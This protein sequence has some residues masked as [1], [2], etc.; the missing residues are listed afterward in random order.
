MYYQSNPWRIPLFS[1]HWSRKTLKKCWKKKNAY[2]FDKEWKN[3]T[4]LFH[5]FKCCWSNNFTEP[6]QQGISVENAL[7]SD[8]F[9]ANDN[10]AMLFRYFSPYFW[11]LAFELTH[12]T[13]PYEWKPI[14]KSLSKTTLKADDKNQH[15]K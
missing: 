10:N 6:N 11:D 14:L 1:F 4:W 9:R 3:E 15:D 8:G 12:R 2:L 5:R 7:L 13:V